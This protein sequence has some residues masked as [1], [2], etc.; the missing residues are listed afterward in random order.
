LTDLADAYAEVQSRLAAT[1]LAL[2]DQQR[3]TV[4]TACPDWTVADVMAHLAGGVVDVTSG[5]AQELR[6]LNLLDQWRDEAVA[7]ARDALT[8]R[9]VLQRRGRT[10]ES[11]VDEWRR[12]S[13]LLFAMLR[14]EAEFP[15]DS[16]LFA[17][18][19]LTNDV[20]VHEG[21]VREAIGLDV[22]PEGHATSAA[23][24]AYAFSLDNRLRVT[25]LPALALRYESKERV[26][27]EGVPTASVTA[28]RTTLVRML[29][30]RLAPDEMCD[31][32]WEG[33][34]RPYLAVIPEYGPSNDT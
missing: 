9:E 32:D 17:G 28:S 11:V 4:L 8:G 25:G 19:I 16:F 5:G 14:G 30:S 27:G 1:V 26:V 2:D 18:N 31:L 10:L 33:D 7:R 22:A 13:T 24:Q 29:A 23:L 21:D 34:P 12:A 20:V 6:G 15:P 3:G